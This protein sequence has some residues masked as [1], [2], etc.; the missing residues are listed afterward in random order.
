MSDELTED[1]QYLLEQHRDMAR[2]KAHGKVIS[3][4]E[5][6]GMTVIMKE[7]ILKPPRN[8]DGRKR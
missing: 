5:A 2:R 3:Q 6:G 1:E 8:G 4:Y 7:E